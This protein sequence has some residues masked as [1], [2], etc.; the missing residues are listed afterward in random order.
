M[1]PG[2][3]PRACSELF[4]AMMAF[5]CQPT[6]TKAYND[7][8]RWRIVWQSEAIGL[9]QIK[10]AQNLCIDQ[11]RILNLFHSTAAVSKMVYPREKA[12]RKLT[13]PA[14]LLVLQLVMSKPGI[15]LMEILLLRLILEVSICR[16]LYSS[17]FS[18]QKMLQV[19]IQRNDYFRAQYLMVVSLYTPEMLFFL[20]EMGADHRNCFRRYITGPKNIFLYKGIVRKCGLLASK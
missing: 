15:Y 9:T 8:L 7:D 3:A 14:Q 20:D 11:S 10:I 19:A 5:S 16:F 4:L 6:R 1:R 13:Y 2:R 18:H 12:F 17:G